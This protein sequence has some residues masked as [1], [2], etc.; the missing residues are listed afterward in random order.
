M[1][2]QSKGDWLF[3]QFGYT[4]IHFRK[5]WGNKSSGKGCLRLSLFAPNKK[6]DWA[7]TKFDVCKQ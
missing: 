3:I 2:S 7:R 5:L 6:R 4:A 1:F